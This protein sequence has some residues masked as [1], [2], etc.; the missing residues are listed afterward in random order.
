[1]RLRVIY[2]DH[3]MLRRGRTTHWGS[4]KPR[5]EPTTTGFWHARRGIIAFD[6]GMI[7][8]KNVNIKLNYNNDS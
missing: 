8:P 7:L 6:D 1:M 3:E 5:V 4:N 2:R